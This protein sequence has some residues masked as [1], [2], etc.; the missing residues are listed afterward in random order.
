MAAILSPPL[1]ALNTPGSGE[2][3]DMGVVARPPEGKLQRPFVPRSIAVMLD[4]TPRSAARR[5]R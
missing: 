5:L 1:L 2:E 4:S 3:S